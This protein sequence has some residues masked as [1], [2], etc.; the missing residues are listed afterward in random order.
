MSEHSEKATPKIDPPQP[1]GYPIIGNALGFQR[2]D[3][4]IHYLN[5]VVREHGDV[6][7]LE[8]FGR[9]MY[10]TRDPEHGKQILIEDNDDTWQKSSVQR[11]QFEV[12]MGR[13]VLT[14][15]GDRWKHQRKLLDPLLRRD[16]LESFTDEMANY[17]QRK[18]GS[19]DE[20][21]VFDVNNI[22]TALAVEIACKALFN[23]DAGEY[24]E[25]VG[26]DFQLVTNHLFKGTLGV[27][28]P[29]WVPTPQNL[30]F[31]RAIDTL[32]TVSDQIIKDRVN[33]DDDVDCLITRTYRMDDQVERELTHDVLRKKVLNMIF[34]GHETTA[35]GLTWTWYLLARNPQVKR[36]LHEELEEK[37][38]GEKPT[39]EDLPRLEYLEAILKESWRM[40][41][42]SYGTM[43]EPTE[44]TTLNGYHIPEGSTLVV[45]TWGI[46]RNP[47]LWDDPFSF[48]PE[49][50]L[51]DS[52]P[53][54]HQFAYAP[55]SGGPR[56]CAGEQFA[57]VES[58]MVLATIAQ[59]Y[60]LELATEPPIDI[61]VS[62]TTQ[63]KNGIDMIPH[64]R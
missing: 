13:D 57:M 37:L 26:K 62:L 34:G 54:D 64:K 45:L 9:E 53:T 30:R 16:H 58:K 48:D 47:D 32:N 14:S 6:A 1:E 61:N 60:D 43:R 51:G 50:W 5:S 18:M 38:G 59:E 39:A 44:D 36:K 46:H 15:E 3:D 20:G 42:P 35:Q 12:F 17:A 24:A 52:P 40:Y 63:P 29:N 49:R 11:S 27:S 41:P 22:M 25:K 21:E 28:P 55:F 8:V 10:L 23:W 7:K 33:A 4:P 56:R 31:K 2:A 19:L